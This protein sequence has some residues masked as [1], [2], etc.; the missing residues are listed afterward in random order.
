MIVDVF[1]IEAFL[2]GS[3]I[4]VRPIRD[5]DM[6]VGKTMNFKVVKIN[7][8]FRNVIVSHKV[9]VESELE[10]KKQD[11]IN[12]LE[13]GQVLEGTVK[14]FAPF[15]VFVDL[16]GVDGLIH[17]K[18]LAWRFIKSPDEVV[19]IGQKIRVK[20]IE[21]SDDKKKISLSRKALL[22]QIENLQEGDFIIGTV[23]KKVDFGVI[24]DIGDFTALASGK[25]LSSINYQ[26]GDVIECNI[27]SNT[28]D[29]KKHRKIKVGNKPECE[30][31]VAS[32]NVG[33]HVE[34]TFLSSEPEASFITVACDDMKIDVSKKAL[35]E[36]YSSKCQEGSL[37]Y[38]E[39]LD[40]VFTNFNSESYKIKLSMTPIIR[41]RE[42]E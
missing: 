40:F 5:Y 6:F 34:V 29:E 18:E 15:G 3:Q 9:I 12:Q 22:P 42:L 25:D 14:N 28:I 27:I 33:N 41:E 4:D 30:K 24:V 31:F 13:N 32:H 19:S 17:I 39:I 35:I 26:I 16:G 1:G 20:V 23:V 7:Q 36:P 11:I 37:A 38:G 8:E 21:I 10:T 2:P